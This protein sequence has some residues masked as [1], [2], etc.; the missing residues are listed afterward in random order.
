MAKIPHGMSVV[1]AVRKHSDAAASY[2][3]LAAATVDARVIDLEK[4][5]LSDAV[6]FLLAGHPNARTGPY[7]LVVPDDQLGAA[8]EML[9]L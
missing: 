9:R 6:K 7:V 5:K 4:F 1:L 2:A 8:R 3:K